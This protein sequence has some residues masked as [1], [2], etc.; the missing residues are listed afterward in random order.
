MTWSPSNDV[1]ETRRVIRAVGHRLACVI[2]EPI[3]GAE[4]DRA[5]LAAL[6]NETARAGALLVIDE[7]KTNCRLA[8]GGA[9]ERY[10]LEPDLVVLG[11][12][13]RMGFLW[14]CSAAAR[15]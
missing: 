10:Q 14:P 2:I 8:I 7:V 9:T 3:V 13:S 12:H 5:W 4:P 6:R 1:E 11:R 15:P